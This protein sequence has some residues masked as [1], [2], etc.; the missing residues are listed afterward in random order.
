[1]PNLWSVNYYLPGFFDGFYRRSLVGTL[2]SVLGTYK[3]N[4]YVIA[5]IQF[6][7]LA[8]LLVWIYTIFRK[9][10]LTMLI[11]TAYFTSACGGFLFHEVGYIDQLLYLTLFISMAIYDRHKLS[12]ILLF[13]SSMFMHELA[14]FV[15]VPLFFSFVYIRSERLKESFLSILPAIF[16][17]VLIYLFFQTVPVDKIHLFTDKIQ[18]YANYAYRYDYYG[19]FVNAFTGERN[20]FHYDLNSIIPLILLTMMNVVISIT[21]YKLTRRSFVA[22]LIAISGFSPLLLGLFG[23]DL[24]R[25]F[26]LSFSSLTIAFILVILHYRVTFHDITSQKWGAVLVISYILFIGHMSI[27][28]FEGDKPRVVNVQA[29]M[30]IEK[31]AGKI[32]KL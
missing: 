16:F 15:T 3:Y 31:R 14:L 27:G 19:V 10:S 7:I 5:G 13:S 26:F 25:W 2:L 8:A 1:M 22:L 23:Y 4:Y 20:R 12:S 18:T 32:P 11:I 21:V 17:F 9:N 30:E 29:L 6:S 24:N 28:F